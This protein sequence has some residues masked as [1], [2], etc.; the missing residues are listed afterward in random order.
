M[1]FYLYS[2]DAI[3]Q[4]PVEINWVPSET[5][6]EFEKA[7]LGFMRLLEERDTPRQ[8]QR[9]IVNYFNANV[10]PQFKKDGNYN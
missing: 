6:T 2:I 7:A 3:F 1:L 9:D 5:L 10:A 4:D 8:H